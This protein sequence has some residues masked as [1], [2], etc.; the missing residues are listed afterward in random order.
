MPAAANAFSV[1]RT[2][3]SV[4]HDAPQSRDPRRCGAHNGPR[5]SRVPLLSAQHPAQ[6]D[7]I[8]RSPPQAG[9]SKD[10]A[11][12]LENALEHDGIESTRRPTSD[13]LAPLAGRG[14]STLA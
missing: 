2:R 10:E 3:S 13:H 4:P 6:G 14:R 11:T 8:L 9:V 5:I 12:A 7:L 1:S